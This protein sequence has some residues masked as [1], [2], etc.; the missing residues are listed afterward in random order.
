MAGYLVQGHRRRRRRLSRAAGDTPA[1][2]KE[3]GPTAA[4]DT[5]R[6]DLDALRAAAMLLGIVLHGALSF[7][8]G[9]WP[10]EDVHAEADS[11]YGLLVVFIHG[12]RMQT[13]FLLSGFF[14]ALLWRRRGLASL[15]R[16]RVL[17][18]ALPLAL[19]VVTIVPLMNWVSGLALR[20][21][22]G[23]R[24][25]ELFEAGSA[26]GLDTWL[27]SFHHLWFLWFLLWLM[28]GFALVALAADRTGR[29]AGAAGVAERQGGTGG[30][31]RMWLWSM[32]AAAL[33]FE[34]WSES[35]NFYKGKHYGSWGPATSAGLVPDLAV[36]GYYAAFFAFGSLLYCARTRGGEPL[37][38]T[39]GSWGWHWIGATALLV[40]VPF[41]LNLTY[42]SDAWVLASVVEVLQTWA[43]VYALIGLFAAL[44][45]RHRYWVRY[46]SD[47]AYWMYL[48]HLPLILAGQRMIDNWALPAGLKFVGLV[49]VVSA[50]LLV[51]YRLFVRYT[52][53]GW[54][55]NGRRAKPSAS[56]AAAQA[57][58]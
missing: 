16:Q 11:G 30:A 35:G 55:L 28:A 5:R 1:G 26:R 33:A 47:A 57:R 54:L 44:M 25:K 2:G 46:V 10:V 40:L 20:D 12:F 42:E 32:P 19:G 27:E 15:L 58:P 52:P 8:K 3:P 49:V 6:H 43:V 34:L 9:F 45:S 38:S 41:G 50:V 53:I 31:T 7:V 17:R 24:W 51:S 39:F 21:R 23:P 36:L 4:S 37:R 48:F 22:F 13:F 56:P 14:T 18:V 29:A